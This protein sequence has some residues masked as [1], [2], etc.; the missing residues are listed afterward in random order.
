MCN[1]N[2][3]FQDI[4]DFFDTIVKRLSLSYQDEI[5]KRFDNM[6]NA[7]IHF[8]DVELLKRAQ[9]YVRHTDRLFGKAL[10]KLI[11]SM[12][13]HIGVS[14]NVV[15][16]SIGK[17][18]FIKSESKR[19]HFITLE[20]IAGFP[21]VPWLKSMSEKTSNNQ[22]LDYYI[23][24]TEKN[25]SSISYLSEIK[26]A[27]ENDCR[28]FLCFED[29]ITTKFSSDIWNYI[30]KV[31]DK[32]EKEASAFQ[33]YEL[34]RVCNP[35]SIN[36]MKS[37]LVDVLCNFNYKNELIKTNI[38]IDTLS[39][40]I[41][42]NQFVNNMGYKVLFEKN[43]F[44]QSLLT[45]E[46]L[47]NNNPINDIL[48][49]TYIITGYIKS[50]EQLLCWI[51]SGFSS[52]YSI[53]I[54]TKNGIKVVSVDSDDFFK[55]TLGNMLFFLKDFENRG[56]YLKGIK[57]YSINGLY[58]IINSWVQNER[59][60]YFHKDNLSNIQELAKI[61]NRTFLVYF[62]LLGSIDMSI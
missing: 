60:G 41:M 2:L 51:I 59:N 52:E 28:Y 12:F 35:T 48:D 20:K 32:I 62:L 36:N 38:Q 31:F 3:L 11:C 1:T 4:D 10:A 43:D 29:F 22:I 34:V 27:L 58:R 42:K 56:I 46:W 50:V 57:N 15:N 33:W 49:N 40:N 21:K 14:A 16:D 37:S 9:L 26:K 24:L 23:L 30:E 5:Y 47:Y 54:N 45:S 13:M 39:F 8:N 18:I 53:S 19:F 61:R 7:I 17:A 6:P 44:S 25:I 55:A